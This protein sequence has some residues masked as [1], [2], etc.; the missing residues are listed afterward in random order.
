MP[1]IAVVIGVFHT[2]EN[3]FHSIELIR[4]EHHQAFFPLMQYNVLANNL[5]QRTLF[6]EN[7]CKLLQVIERHVGSISPVERELI[8]TIRVIGE[9][10]GVH[11][12]GNDK[13]LDVIKQTMERSFVIT[14][15]LVIGLL[16]LHASAF[17]FYLD[18][19]QAVDEYCH[20]ISTLL[21]SINRNLVRNL[22]LVLAPMC[23][24]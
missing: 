6:E 8:T 9:I 15:Y 13:Q 16:K 11:T 23:A 22:K 21:S 12:I 17:Q 3:F 4:A 24:V 18:Q 19:R 2:V 10:A 1:D 5:S 20:V 14:L 7:R